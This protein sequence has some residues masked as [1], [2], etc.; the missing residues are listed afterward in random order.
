MSV[1]VTS[2][3]CSRS[4]K[5]GDPRT[6]E[7]V[8]S[9]VP[10][11]QELPAK[12]SSQGEASAGRRVILCQEVNPGPIKRLSIIKHFLF[13]RHFIVIFIGSFY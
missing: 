6:T 3:Q 5:S 2:Q 7:S 10:A 1:A 8:P 12:S 11:G 4:K 9:P 13:V